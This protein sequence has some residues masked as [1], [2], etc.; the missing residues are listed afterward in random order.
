MLAP[1]KLVTTRRNARTLRA[2]GI[3]LGFGH[4]PAGTSDLIE[5]T[6]YPRDLIVPTIARMSERRGTTA[7]HPNQRRADPD[8]SAAKHERRAVP[9]VAVVMGLGALIC[10]ALRVGSLIEGNAIAPARPVSTERVVICGIVRDCA[11]AVPRMRILVERL[12]ALYSDYRVVVIENDSSDRTPDRL[13]SWARANPRV[14]AVTLRLKETN[15]RPSIGFL[16]SVRNRYLDIIE[17]DPEY[18]SFGVLA[19]IDLD[20]DDL[21]LSGVAATARW[22]DRLAR[23]GTR[24]GG[25]TANGVTG[26]GRYFDIFAY[27]HPVTLVWPPERGVLFLNERDGRPLIRAHQRIYDPSIP[28]FPVDSGFGGLAL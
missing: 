10:V 9:R 28:P 15:K 25:V 3:W 11:D 19:V 27:R 13:R 23:D 17:R 26:D 21:D 24:W 4:R 18:V 6:A 22:C 8:D 14:R 20:L 1:T 12:G 16:A 2:R 7:S 5:T